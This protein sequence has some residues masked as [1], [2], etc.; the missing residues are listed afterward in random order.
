MKT[1]IID[2]NNLVHRTYWTAKNTSLKQNISDQA[3]INDFHVYFT[4]N[5]IHSYITKYNPTKTIVVWDEKPEYEKNIRKDLHTEYKGNRSNDASPHQNNSVIKEF[6]NK[7]GIKSIFPRELEAD[8]IVAFLCNELDGQKY[9]VSVDRDFLQLISE[10]V[11]LYDPKGKIEFNIHNF[12][13]LTG[14]VNVDQWLE[15]KYLLGDKSDNVAGV[16]K[17][18]LVKVQKYLEGTLR[19]NSE[20]QDIYNRNKELFC[21]TNHVLS[22][23]EKEYYTKQLVETVEPSWKEFIDLCKQYNFNSIL[24]KKEQWYNSIFLSS[25]MLQLFA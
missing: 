3:K 20:Q 4:L 5:A 16:P 6:L 25:K 13:S 1:V 23:R 17:F 18:G 15:A 24:Q 22:D 19:L 9:I 7:M 11:T 14:Y 12:T 21:L 10:D 8:D 2:G